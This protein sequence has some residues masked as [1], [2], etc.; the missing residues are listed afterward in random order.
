M[1]E[2]DLAD[3]PRL[4]LFLRAVLQDA[5]AVLATAQSAPDTLAGLIETD[6]ARAQF[7]PLFDPQS[8]AGAVL[9]AHGA[10]R[11][12][13]RLFAEERG[14]RYIDP[15][16]VQRALRSGKPVVVP[17]AVESDAGSESV[18]FAYAPAAMAFPLWR[19]PPELA[20]EAP[21]GKVVV[22]TTLAARAEP[23]ER[24]CA[25]F[26]L[27]GLQ[28]RV[29]MNVVRA[30]SIKAAAERLGISH[31]TARE[32]LSDVYRR[33][34]ARRL[35]ELVG[36]LSGLAFGLLPSQPDHAPLLVDV[37][38]LTQK[39]ASIALL[40]ASGA[41]RE[42]AARALGLSVAV[43]RKELEQVFAALRVSSA[44]ELARTVSTMSALAALLGA[45]R[46][47]LGFADPRAEPLRLTPRADGTRIAWSDYGP[48]GGRPVLIVHSSM[49]S[50][51][52][53]SGLVSA[54]QGAGFR[55]LAVDRP[56]FGMSDPVAGLRAGEHDP[57]DAAAT[58]L[59]A[60]LDVLRLPTVDIVARGG[61]QAV[62][63][64]ARRA[65][66]RIGRVVLVNPDPPSGSDDRRHG[67][68]GAFKE[69]YLRR[70]ELI[71]TFARVL[72]GSLT[73]ERLHRMVVQSMR[74]SPPDEAAAADPRIAEDYWRSVRMF[75]T[76]RIAGYVNEQVAIA[77]GGKPET[78]P[79]LTEWTV[80]IG[81]HDTMHDPEH[82]ERY[83]REVLPDSRFERISDAG[84]F[85]AMTHPQRVIDALVA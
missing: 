13:S 24:A 38:G 19:L 29:V 46:G 14:E 15:G 82:V 70:P 21:A 74:G 61:A 58:D 26:G 66:E 28:T 63:A 75:A 79:A 32:A 80:L 53:P 1:S 45:T 49:T 47:Q 25:T 81:A 3:E 37:W 4:P 33:T 36:L 62:L 34:G 31:V 43:V 67:P 39:Q 64:L 71:G 22:L 9:D 35:P 72:A 77:R 10:V 18:I 65:P 83:W 27:T 69:A 17:V 73:R 78:A 8:I 54:L 5:E 16:L 48:A 12:A 50:R 44:S 68:L 57:F 30:G 20:D 6:A 76:G 51:L 42:E 84:R 2:D 11:V 52:A 85:L 60:L 59:I 55:V 23:I 56:G 41:S 40:V 7:L